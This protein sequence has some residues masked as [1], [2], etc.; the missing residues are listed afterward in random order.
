MAA[1]AECEAVPGAEG[2]PLPTLRSRA[3]ELEAAPRKEAHDSDTDDDLPPLIDSDSD[4]E[5]VCLCAPLSVG[6]CVQAHSQQKMSRVVV[7]SA[8]LARSVSEKVCVCEAFACGDAASA[9]GCV[10][11]FVCGGCVQWGGEGWVA[12]RMRRTRTWQW[13]GVCVEMLCECSECA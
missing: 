13:L 12:V 2:R 11:K 10:G 6:G 7:S 8:A 1:K 9:L 3:E 4:S 5:E